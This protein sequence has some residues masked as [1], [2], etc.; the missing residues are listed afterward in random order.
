MSWSVEITLSEDRMEAYLTIHTDSEDFPSEQELYKEIKAASVVYGI[1][2]NVI[3]SVLK[4]A[5]PVWNVLFA[6][7]I[8]TRENERDNLT[9]F[10]DLA[11]ASKPKIR[12]DGYADFKEMKRI[13][14][15]KKGQELVSQL[16]ISAERYIK[17]VTGE[18]HNL[19]QSYLEMIKGDHIHISGDGLT[20]IADIDGCAFWKS[21]KLTVDNIYHVPGDVSF[22]TG[23]IDFAGTVLIDGDVRSGFRVKATGSIYING[24][25]E[26]A[27]VYSQSGD[28]VVRSG[29]LGKNRAK[30]RAG[31]NV[32]CRYIQ[33]TTVVAK[34]DVVIEHYAFNSGI[35]AGGRIFLMQNEG[36]IRGG[37]AFAE[38]GMRA[39]EVGSKQAT[40]T[41]IGITGTAYRQAD[42][43]RLELEKMTQKLTS[44]LALKVKKVEFLQLLEERLE[45]LSE[46][47][48][49][50]LSESIK[51]I[52]EIEKQLKQIEDQKNKMIEN[53]QRLQ[54]QKSID[55]LE[56]LHRGVTIT[57]GDLQYHNPAM[58]KGA[59]IYR[60]G[61][62]IFIENYGKKV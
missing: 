53:N 51:E 37:K 30:I 44:K 9:W 55:V 8:N 11:E 36:L 58:I 62:E 22:A 47:K 56:T 46:E 49:I 28:I 45:T 20:L 29:I 31:G 13:E 50:S 17:T 34:K 24:N 59:K 27:E 32:S 4:E 21:G 42:L 52:E 61:N 35:S 1:D 6:Q 57:I 48:Q 19:E 40:P 39:V 54:R 38:K 14:I 26:A 16:P 2:K 25:V 5:K 15:V 33:N 60:K 23:N 10:V 12:A 18:K 43:K 41:D 3:A 7:G